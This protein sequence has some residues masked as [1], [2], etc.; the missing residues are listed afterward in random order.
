MKTTTQGHRVV[1]RQLGE[2]PIDALENHMELIPMAMP[3]GL[4][5]DD[6]VIAVKAAAVGWVDLIM[7]SGQYQ[8]TVA[9]PY[10]PGLEYAGTVAAV[11]A[12]VHNLALGAPVLVDGFLAGP[13]SSGAHQREGGFATWAIAPAAAIIPIPGDLSFSEACNLLGNYETAWHCLISRGRLRAGETV[14][15]LGASGATG[16]AA[17]EVAKRTGARVI[18][19]GRDAGRLESVKAAGADETVVMPDPATNPRGLR[20]A[21]KA[22]T[23]GRGVDVVYDGV[24]GPISESAMRCLCFGGRFLIVGWA[25]TPFV[26]DGGGRRGAPNVNVL[27]TNIMMMKGLD[28]L[29][30]PTVIATQQDPSIRAERLGT[31]LAWAAEGAIRPR[32]SHTF[33]L[34]S[35][36]EA[37]RLKW[38]GGVTGGC[39]V[40][41]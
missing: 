39:V 35:F 9:P 37:M 33:E 32:V 40:I 28:V 18:A 4:G 8:H 10:T 31:I 5:P 19:V 14:L 2:D 21:V 25:S 7:A 38:A 16:L 36:K 34:K 22:L 17:V 30:C 3:T 29:G 41:P 12:A 26:A 23:D 11:G 27:P 13:R 24:G 15:I 1:L 6:V 20:D